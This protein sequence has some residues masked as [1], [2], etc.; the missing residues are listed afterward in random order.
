M[1]A[2]LGTK[3]GS[4]GARAELR[5]DHLQQGVLDLGGERIPFGRRHD[6]EPFA[7]TDVD[8]ETVQAEAIGARSAPV[9]V[10]EQPGAAL[11]RISEHQVSLLLE[12][13][14]QIERPAPRREAVVRHHDQRGA[15][16]H[17]LQRLADH[18]VE[19]R[20]RFSITPLWAHYAPRLAVAAVGRW[21]KPRSMGPGGRIASAAGGAAWPCAKASSKRAWR[22]RACWR[23]RCIGCG[24]GSRDASPGRCVEDNMTLGGRSVNDARPGP[25]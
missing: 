8:I 14:V 11:R 25:N 7:A 10:L 13:P 6:P 21:S 9:D 16:R 23:R 22:S 20:Y 4:D 5:I 24:L 12:P 18:R 15:G 19:P 17:V 3:D 1:V 2:A